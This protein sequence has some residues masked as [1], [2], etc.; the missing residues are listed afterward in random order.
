MNLI[1]RRKKE[2]VKI[3][4][5]YFEISRFKKSDQLKKAV[6]QNVLCFGCVT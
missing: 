6:S 5:F 3:S 4:M 2:N 1:F